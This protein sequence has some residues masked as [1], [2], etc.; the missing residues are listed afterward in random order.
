MIVAGYA[1]ETPRLLLNS[2]S[3]LF[4]DGLANSSG[5]VGK[6]FM[7]HTGEQVFAKFPARI[8]QYKEPPGGAI[9]VVPPSSPILLRARG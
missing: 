4:P 9:T 2:A 6:C 3:S 1:V 7:V 5:L 8:N